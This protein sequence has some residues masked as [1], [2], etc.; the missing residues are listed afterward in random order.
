MGE[1]EQLHSSFYSDNFQLDR[2]VASISDHSGNSPLMDRADVPN[3]QE[4]ELGRLY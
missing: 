2:R 1:V 3:V 4:P